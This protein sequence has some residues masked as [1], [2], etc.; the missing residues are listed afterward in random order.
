MPTWKAY[1]DEKIFRRSTDYMQAA[2]HEC[3][4]LHEFFIALSIGTER[5]RPSEGVEYGEYVYAFAIS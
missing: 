2:V 3:V 1:D 4:L 5:S